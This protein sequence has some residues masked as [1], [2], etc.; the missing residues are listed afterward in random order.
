MSD[1]YV[2][3]LKD[4]SAKNFNI[5]ENFIKI[6]NYTENN[7]ISLRGR[8]FYCRTLCVYCD[9]ADAAA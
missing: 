7:D 5:C 4:L 8:L 6:L 3:W 1:V 2:V 9:N